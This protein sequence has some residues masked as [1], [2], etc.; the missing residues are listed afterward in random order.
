[1]VLISCLEL[2]IASTSH[3]I[4]C[5]LYTFIVYKC[6]QLK[7]LEEDEKHVLHHGFHLLFLYD[8]PIQVMDNMGVWTKNEGLG[9]I[10]PSDVK[11]GEVI[12]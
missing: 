4:P 3:Y 12:P 9:L 8:I 7:A 6:K 5:I 11:K 10:K 1:M 2:I